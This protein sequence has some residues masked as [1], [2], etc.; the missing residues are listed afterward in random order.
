[1]SK[2]TNPMSVILSLI[3]IIVALVVAFVVKGV[4][5]TSASNWSGLIFWLIVIVIGGGGTFACAYFMNGKRR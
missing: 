4:L 5:P 1:M 2:R 3:L